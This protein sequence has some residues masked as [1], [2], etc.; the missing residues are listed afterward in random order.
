[1][2]TVRRVPVGVWYCGGVAFLLLGCAKTSCPDIV[3]A[4]VTESKA[5]I[6][7]DAF[8]GARE[9]VQSRYETA[10]P[11]IFLKGFTVD[12]YR[13][14]LASFPPIR[15]EIEVASHEVLAVVVEVL[16]ARFLAIDEPE[17]AIA[18]VV[19]SSPHAP[20]EEDGSFNLSMW[21]DGDRVRVRKSTRN[22]WSPDSDRAIGG[23]PKA[24][25]E[26]GKE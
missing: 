12:E 25:I 21:W 24:P 22:A 4:S 19:R 15:L 6:Y 2:I 8:Y 10:A 11:Y 26:T 9:T 23:S 7:A 1:M 16:A 14:A 3:V 18:F 13:R 17:I 20:V 5:R